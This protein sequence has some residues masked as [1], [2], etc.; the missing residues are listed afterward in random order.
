VIGDADPHYNAKWVDDIRALPTQKVLVV[1]G[2]HHGLE[3]GD[4]LQT[5]QVL[6]RI[7]QTIQ[8]FL[9]K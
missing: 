5:I 1:D 2:A 9:T 3:V 8:N 6:E 4:A 7:M